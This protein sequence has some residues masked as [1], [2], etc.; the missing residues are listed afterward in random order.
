MQATLKQ[1][2]DSQQA[3]QLLLESKL[4][5]KAAYAVSKLAAA[6]LQEL[7]D[8]QAARAKIFTD[9]G[10]VVDANRKEWVHPDGK[11]RRDEAVKQADELLGATVTLN[12]TPLDL[13]QFKDV[14]VPGGAFFALDW[15]MKAD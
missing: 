2:N 9:G 8:Y 6:C 11:E 4:P 5:A 1:L 13:E 10:C 15:A 3:V 14:E 7:Q 12:V